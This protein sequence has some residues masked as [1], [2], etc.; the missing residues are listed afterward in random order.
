MGLGFIDSDDDNLS[1]E[2]F[3]IVASAVSEG[4]GDPSMLPNAVGL[5]CFGSDEE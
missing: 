1:G 2:R 3:V 4:G 5:R